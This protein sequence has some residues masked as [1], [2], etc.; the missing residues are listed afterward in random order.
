MNRLV[1]QILPFCLL[2]F[3]LIGHQPVVGQEISD[4]QD[5][6][7]SLSTNMSKFNSNSYRAFQLYSDAAQQLTNRG[8]YQLADSL[9]QLA[10]P[11][12]N[13]ESDS[14]LLM[15][16]IASRAS[17]NK[18]QGR[19]S[20][21]LED[22]LTILDYY[23]RKKDI[24]HLVMAQAHL[25]E[26]YRTI[27]NQVR[28]A[29]YI[30]E[31][32]RWMKNDA[33]DSKHKAYFY[34]RAAAFQSEF[35]KDED[36]TIYYSNKALSFAIEANDRFC[37]ALSQNE[38]GFIYMNIDKRDTAR[39]FGFFRAASDNFL[40][41]QRYRDYISVM[42]NIARNYYMI[43]IPTKAIETLEMAIDI[44]E[45]NNWITFLDGS[46]LLLAE[47]YRA[48]GDYEMYSDYMMKA[49]FA[50][51]ETLNDEHAIEASELTANFE[52]DIAERK[53]QEQQVQTQLA[54]ER[55]RDNRNALIAT[56]I[57]SV[58]LLTITI[59][60]VQLYFRFRKKNAQFS[61]QQ[62]IIQE[63]N[64]Q[65][66]NALDQQNVLYR[67]LNHRVKNN[68]TVLSGLIYL[69]ESGETEILQK[70]IYETLRHR[71]QS[72]A[73]VHQNLYEFNEALN[74]NFQDYLRQLIPNI[75]NA[76][77]GD[78][79]VST[80]IR[81]ENLIVNI[82]EAVPLAM[83]INEL[84]TNSFKHAFNNVDKGKIELWSKNSD[85]NRAI[86]YRDN[87]PGQE[88][89][90]KE[91]NPKSLGMRLVKLMVAQLKGTLTYTGNHTGVCYKI[92]LR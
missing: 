5:L 37:I 51:I 72:I 13:L 58:V 1:Q 43:D 40:S 87:G 54:Q 17:M 9:F 27:Q 19:F 24:N 55:A 78:N 38:L 45:A 32:L 48:L 76:F 44:A 89:M 22:Y 63:T 88:T 82:D 23:T 52:K 18:I 75:A 73:I 26:Y 6:L 53:L 62:K 3:Y 56:I 11:L 92:E 81:C 21:A 77:S 47:S 8:N 80:S 65:L 20:K 74:L 46:Y 69:Q 61:V 84:I 67:E 49:Y 29:Q 57:I 41:I 85:G 16:L 7:D 4:P 79:R 25:I 70:E 34:S 68:L 60:S 39:S 35:K 91:S 42:E 59:I 64:A 90:D 83:I 28:V 71:I 36:S 15:E 31:G 14:T 66:T 86:Y 10:M 33:V 30:Y 2:L 50:K 12:S